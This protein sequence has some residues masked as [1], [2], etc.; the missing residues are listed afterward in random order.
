MEATCVM[1][2]LG[3]DAAVKHAG[4]S[5]FQC[6]QLLKAVLRIHLILIRIRIRVRIQVLNI[7]LRFTDFLYLII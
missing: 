3:T 6:A 5:Q 2:A 4:Q 1:S 7:S